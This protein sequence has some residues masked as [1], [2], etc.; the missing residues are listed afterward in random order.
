MV[1]ERK[2]G[3]L[4]CQQKAG[5]FRRGVRESCHVKRGD[6]RHNIFPEECAC[7]LPTRPRCACRQCCTKLWTQLVVMPLLFY[8]SW[9]QRD[10][11]MVV[12]SQEAGRALFTTDGTRW[13]DWAFGYVFGA[14][15]MEDLLLD[16]VDT[17]MIWHHIGCCVGHILA[18]AVLPYGFPYYFGGAVALEFGSALYNLYC[19]YPSSKGM[20]W[21][22]LASMTLSNAVAACFCYT[23]LTLDFPLSAKVGS[24][25]LS[26]A[27]I[28]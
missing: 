22:F 19:L 15:L 24:L 18:F 6:R 25:P 27:H 8:L 9:A 14:Y 5:K 23:W 16:T 13:Y 2:A 17:L 10:F 1:W 26:S 21:T 20:A 7:P 11:S 3:K 4:S 12:W 28:L